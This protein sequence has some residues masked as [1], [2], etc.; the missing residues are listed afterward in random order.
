MDKQEKQAIKALKGGVYTE[1]MRQAD[2]DEEA[3]QRELHDWFYRQEPSPEPKSFR[4]MTEI[5]CVAIGTG[6]ASIKYFVGEQEVH[7]VSDELVPKDNPWI[8]HIG[9]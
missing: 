7:L 3:R 2:R 5:T 6:D 4:K 1:E 9:N 8:E